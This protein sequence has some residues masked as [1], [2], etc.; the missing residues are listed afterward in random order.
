[1][2]APN[3]G[4][5]MLVRLVAVCFMLIGFLDLALYL[6]RCFEPKHPLPVR[7]APIVSNSIPAALGLVI[8]AR[9]RAIAQWISDWLE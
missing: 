4:A 9:A 1:M 2:D 3:R 8:L 6:T 7:V 5:L